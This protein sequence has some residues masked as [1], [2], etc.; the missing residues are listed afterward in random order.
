MKQDIPT[1]LGVLS[2]L[3]VAGLAVFAVLSM[4]QGFKVK[5]SPQGVPPEITPPTQ[6]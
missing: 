1:W 3:V 4:R 6:P 2:L 5:N